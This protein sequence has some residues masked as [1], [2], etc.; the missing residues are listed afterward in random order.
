[1]NTL[2]NKKMDKKIGIFAVLLPSSSILTAQSN[3]EISQLSFNWL[4]ST[5]IIGI[6]L[7]GIIAALVYIYKK[8]KKIRRRLKD[9]LNGMIDKKIYANQYSSGTSKTFEDLHGQIVKLQEEINALKNNDK[10]AESNR[11]SNFKSQ[12]NPTNSKVKYLKMKS[13]IYLSQESY[14]QLNSKFKIFDIQGNT[15][16]FEFCGN[17]LEAIANREAFFD[18]VCDDSNYSPTAK[19]IVNEQHGV[20]ELQGDGKWKVITKATIKFV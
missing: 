8:I 13:G 3:D 7:I 6:I 12:T 11:H 10:H 15:A 16:K 5:I 2:N 17:E 14:S 18:N 19:Q 9:E 1:M 4:C 20:V